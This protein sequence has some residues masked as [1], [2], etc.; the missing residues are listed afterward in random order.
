MLRERL[1]DCL[2]VVEEDVDPDRRVRACHP[3]HVA[4][5]AT[6]RSQRIVALDPGRAGLVHEQVGK[7]VRQM[8]RQRHQTVVCLRVDGHRDS[9]ELADE[10]MYEPVAGG[11]GRVR[12]RRAPRKGAHPRRRRL[13]DRAL[14]ACRKANLRERCRALPLAAARQPLSLSL[15][16]RARRPLACRLVP[17]DARQGRG[18]A[19]EPEP[20]CRHDCTRRRRRRALARL[21]EGPRRARDA[22]RS[23]AQRP[24][25]G[26]HAGVCTRRALPRA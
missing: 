13:P 12:A 7:C 11:V 8:A 23:G 6:D 1:G 15:P 14:P 2:G 21:R 17:R 9:P 26:V 24:L 16:P 25:A 20:D 19:G 18:A 5:G 4:Q 10:T 3:R 22:R